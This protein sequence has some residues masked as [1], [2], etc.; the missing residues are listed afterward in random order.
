MPKNIDKRYKRTAPSK[1]IISREG[2]RH[3]I[4]IHKNKNKNFLVKDYAEFSLISRTIFKNIAWAMVNKL[5]GVYVKGLGYFC[6]WMSPIKMTHT[7]LKAKEGKLISLMNFE[8]PYRYNPHLF[9]DSSGF[10]ALHGWSMER[11]FHRDIRIGISE[12]LYNFK[13]YTF[14]WSIIKKMFY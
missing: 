10:S 9:A 4:S 2:F 14:H 6:V 7:L 5:G 13:P 11:T 3:Y 12:N 8:E 1:K